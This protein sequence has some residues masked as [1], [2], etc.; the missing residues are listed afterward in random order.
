MVATVSIRVAPPGAAVKLMSRK[1][2]RASPT[3]IGATRPR[4]RIGWPTPGWLRLSRM[5]GKPPPA[6]ANSP[7]IRATPRGQ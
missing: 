6:S 1:A 2:S 3:S 5:A 7:S 4:P